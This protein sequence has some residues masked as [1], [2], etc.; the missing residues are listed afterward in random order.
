MNQFFD[1][2]PEPQTHEPEKMRYRQKVFKMVNG[3]NVEYGKKKKVEEDGTT[4]RK[5]RKRDQLKEKQPPV[6]FKKQS[7]FSSACHTERS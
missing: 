5:K 1:G 6:L 4:A 7:C 2:K 3:I